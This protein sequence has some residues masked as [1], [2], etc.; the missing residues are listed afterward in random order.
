MAARRPDI[1]ADTTE[2]T[3]RTMACDL[4]MSVH[5]TELTTQR[6]EDDVRLCSLCRNN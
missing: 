6:T 5:H 3:V 2:N 4:R 1:P